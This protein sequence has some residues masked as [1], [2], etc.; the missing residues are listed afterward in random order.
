MSDLE[1][2]IQAAINIFNTNLRLFGHNITL[3]NVCM[4][5][6]I[7]FLLLKLFFGMMR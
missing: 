6:I 4:Y 1:Q 5:S 2:I 3:F 7:G